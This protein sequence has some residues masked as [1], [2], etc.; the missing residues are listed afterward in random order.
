MKNKR[1]ERLKEYPEITEFDEQQDIRQCCIPFYCRPYHCRPY[2]CRP[3]RLCRPFDCCNPRA[4][5]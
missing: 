5:P 4:I 1:N 2:Y 3:Y